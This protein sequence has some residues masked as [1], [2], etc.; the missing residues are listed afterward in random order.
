M[1]PKPMTGIFI[2]AKRGVFET[3]GEA[4]GGK[5]RQRP[6]VGSQ[7]PRTP[8]ATRSWNLQEAILPRAL[9][10]S[11]SVNEHISVYLSYR[12]RGTL[13]CQL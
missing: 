7:K 12:I 1:T 9:P 2:R 3:G 5:Q 8:A 6:E 11:R 13:L 10:A 4:H